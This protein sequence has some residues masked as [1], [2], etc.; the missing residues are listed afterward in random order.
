MQG[1]FPCVMNANTT[2]V[3]N[4]YFRDISGGTFPTGSVPFHLVVNNYWMPYQYLSIRP[5]EV[6]GNSIIVNVH[7]EY[8]GNK[9]SEMNFR[10]VKLDLIIDENNTISCVQ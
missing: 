5:N 1:R 6:T 10:S 4:V 9:D 7:N 8:T 3:V 2:T